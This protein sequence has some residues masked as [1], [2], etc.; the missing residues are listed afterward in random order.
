MTYLFLGATATCYDSDTFCSNSWIY[1]PSNCDPD[2]SK[3]LPDVY[4]YCLTNDLILWKKGVENGASTA[5][6]PVIDYN[7][8]ICMESFSNCGYV[9]LNDKASSQCG[10][11]LGQSGVTFGA[12][13]D[14]GQ[15]TTETLSTLGATE[16]T[17]SILENYIGLTGSTAAEKICDQPF[18]LDSNIAY[19]M[20]I[21]LMDQYANRFCERIHKNISVM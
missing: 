21:K 15:Q 5:T 6:V 20:S 3:A 11:V 4:K 19:N 16:K 10:Q 12:G 18:I 7:F 14:L 2:L 17:L 13:I 1:S 8:L 9:P